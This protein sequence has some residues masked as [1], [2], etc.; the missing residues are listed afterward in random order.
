MASVNSSPYASVDIVRAGTAVSVF[1]LRDTITGYYNVTLD[2]ETTQYTAQSIWEEGT[3]LFYMTGLDP[4]RTH[5]LIITNAE[6]N[7]LAIGYI[8]I[9]SVSGIPM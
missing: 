3:V 5:S 2:G 4:G 9:T 6:D 8:N 7:L 1:G